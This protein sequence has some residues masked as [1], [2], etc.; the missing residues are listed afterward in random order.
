MAT[1]NINKGYKH[2][3]DAFQDWLDA[4]DYNFEDIVL[5]HG[6]E[7]FREKHDNWHHYAVEVEQPTFCLV[8]EYEEKEYDAETRSGSV[9]YIIK[10]SMRDAKKWIK[11]KNAEAMAALN[12]G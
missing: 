5:E 11:T 6:N 2:I 9:N 1:A 12:L 7:V 4:N 10:G 8:C 3:T